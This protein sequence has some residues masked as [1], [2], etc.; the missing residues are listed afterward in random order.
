MQLIELIN[1]AEFE[2]SDKRSIDRVLFR[3]KSHRYSVRLNPDGKTCSL[4]SDNEKVDDTENEKVDCAD[5][6][7]IIKFL[8]KSTTINVL[9]KSNDSEEVESL[10]LSK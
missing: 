3:M 4:W 6:S 1:E 8:K 2:L 10:S 5:E 9:F 7:D